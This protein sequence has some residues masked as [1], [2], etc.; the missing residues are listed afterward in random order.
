M[1]YRAAF[2]LATA[3]LTLF[4]PHAAHKLYGAENNVRGAIIVGSF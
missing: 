3:F 4:N 1:I 2:R